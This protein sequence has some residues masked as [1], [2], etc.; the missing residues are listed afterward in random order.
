V[1]EV[2]SGG[3]AGTVETWS[4]PGSFR[5]PHLTLVFTQSGHEVARTRTD[6]RGVF[7]IDLPPGSYAVDAYVPQSDDLMRMRPARLHIRPSFYSRVRLVWDIG[8]R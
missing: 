1:P 3:V 4:G 6:E 7:A 5:Q 2:G 8:S